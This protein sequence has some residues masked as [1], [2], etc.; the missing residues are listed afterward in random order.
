MYKFIELQPRYNLQLIISINIPDKLKLFGKATYVI[1]K[2]KCMMISIY[3]AG[4][5]S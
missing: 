5:L 4:L 2:Y 3:F 1:P